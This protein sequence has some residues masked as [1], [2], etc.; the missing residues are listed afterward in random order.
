MSPSDLHPIF[1]K[2]FFSGKI[3][4]IFNAEILL[5]E[6]LKEVVHIFGEYDGDII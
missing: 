3:R 6:L 2:E 1:F 4:P 5:F